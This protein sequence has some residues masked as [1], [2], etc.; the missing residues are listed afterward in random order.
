MITAA[1]VVSTIDDITRFHSAHEFEA[2]LGLVAGE[3]SSAERRLKGR[4]TK[5]G[6]ARA[7]WLLVEA[8]WGILRSR[9]PE[10]ATLR[11]WGLNIAA[12]RGNQIAAVAVARRLAGI[13]FAMWRDGVPY[14]PMKIRSGSPGKHSRTSSAA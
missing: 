3:H 2:Y 4:I 9:K 5:T 14:D 8:G 11:A 7:R 12:R 10:T 13:L 1:A 6:N